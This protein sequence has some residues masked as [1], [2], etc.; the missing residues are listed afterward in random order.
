MRILAVD[1]G[2]G[3]QDVLVYEEGK[4]IENSYKLVL[5]SPTR[6]FSREVRK[7]KEDL[8]I[9]GDTMGG[10]PF[11]RAVIDHVKKYKV[12]MTEDAARTIRDNLKIVKGY[13]IEI[14]SD[15]EVENIRGK[16]LRISDFV[17][18]IIGLLSSF[19]VDTSF[20]AI[21]IA[22]QDHGI[23]PEGTTDRENRFSLIKKGLG[24]K[25][26]SLSYLN[27]VPENLSRMRSVLH[28]VR[29]WY[30][31][32]VLLM[33]TGP[34]AILGSMEDE[35]VRDKSSIIGVN[36]GNGHTIGMSI[37][38]RKVIGVFEHHTH[39]LDKKKLEYLIKR[40][41]EGKITF[42]EVFEDG[43]HGAVSIGENVP[44]I[45][46][47]TGP[48][49]EKMKGIGIFSAPGGDTMM[50]GPIGLIKAVLDRL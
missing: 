33:D 16:K 20:D 17:G 43:G 19:G 6:M 26:E 21:A 31:G 41:Y 40:L 7:T 10:G 28:S 11:S 36:V 44:E 30:D 32:D 5:P 35:R 1:I 50:T 45:I 8:V 24:K 25:I 29:R 15:D 12:Y 2:V 18:S 9:Y 49:R 48:K 14:I 3:T 27:H 23:S 34:A 47:L 46:S 39:L 38:E 37:S 13:G 42:K 22:V 4:E